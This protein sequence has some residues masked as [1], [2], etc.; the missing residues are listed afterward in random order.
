MTVEEQML[1]PTQSIRCIEGVG[2][3]LATVLESAGF[4]TVQQLRAF[5]CEDDKIWTALHK[6]QTER[7]TLGLPALP[8]S[9]YRRLMTMTLNVINRLRGGI[10]C[11]EPVPQQFRCP[12]T[13]DWLTDPVVAPNGI[14]Y[15]RSAILEWLDMY[16]GRDPFRASENLKREDLR[17]A[18][19]LKDATRFFMRNHRRF[20]IIC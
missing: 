2:D 1:S 8:Q 20:T 10:D 11:D 16:P 18:K 14:A 7:E 9:Y 19:A 6:L 15:E 4:H 13:L 17:T 12:I 3:V 5:E